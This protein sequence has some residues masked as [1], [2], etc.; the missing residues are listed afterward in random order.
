MTN[1][2]L[3]GVGAYAY[4]SAPVSLTVTLAVDGEW[5]QTDVQLG[6]NHW[7]RFGVALEAVTADEVIVELAWHGDVDVSLWGLAAGP[8]E[9]PDAL[10]DDVPV[11]ELNKTHLAPETFYLVQDV[12]LGLDLDEEESTIFTE[13]PGETVTLKKCSYC[14]RMLPVDSDRLGTLAFHKHNAKPTKHQNECRA[15]K[16]WRIND[17]FNPLRTTDQ[18]HESSLITRERRLFLRDPERLQQYKKREGAGLKSQIWERFGRQCFYCGKRLELTEVQ[19]DHTRPLAYLWP[20][21]EFATC[22]CAVHNNQ[23]T[24]KFPVDFYNDHQLRELSQITGLPYTELTAKAVNQDELE[25]I[26]L[27]IVTFAREW[28]PRTFAA[29]ARKVRELMPH[30]DLFEELK[31][32][33]EY[34]HAELVDALAKRPLG[35]QGL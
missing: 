19:L 26:R 2:D 28:E 4:P 29:T 32:A 5:V 10:V 6:G 1:T 31:A 20:I 9:L 34:V 17:S 11:S 35:V 13:V 3:V 33:D 12:A 14:Q 27:D 21:D 23:K 7:N 22:L 18:L 24:D 15:C 16:K 30:V 8:L 25:R